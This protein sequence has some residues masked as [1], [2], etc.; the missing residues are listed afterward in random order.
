MKKIFTLLAASVLTLGAW[1]DT[2]QLNP[3][4]ISAAE[5]GKTTFKSGYLFTNTSSKNTGSG[6]SASDGNKY[7]KFSNG[8]VYT[9]VIPENRQVTSVSISGGAR[10][11]TEGGYIAELNSQA[12]GSTDYVIPANLE[13]GTGV[14][15]A[16]YDFTFETPAKGSITFK[17][18][19][20]SGEALFNFVLTD[21]EKSDE[22]SE[23]GLAWSIDNL[24]YKIRDNV[25]APTFL[26]P[27]S[28]PVTFKTTDATIA[29]VDENGVVTLKNDKVGTAK[30]SATFAGN[31]DYPKEVIELTVDVVTNE[32][33]VKQVKPGVE[34]AIFDLDKMFYANDTSYPEGEIFCR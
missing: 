12:F 20:G 17:H 31:D 21:E 26:N 32:V 19:G 3:G 16:K 13:K 4:N 34:P 10:G 29:A 6:N 27:N 1:A 33:D 14:V 15:A 11:T 18:A 23:S 22:V 24:K 28:L 30:I 7:I 2:V 8:V 9:I 5:T 25:E